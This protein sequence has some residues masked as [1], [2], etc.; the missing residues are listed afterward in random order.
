MN[1]LEKIRYSSKV[2][3]KKRSPEER[4]TM[5]CMPLMLSLSISLKKYYYMTGGRVVIIAIQV[6]RYESGK[7]FVFANRVH[8]DQF[9][10]SETT[11]YNLH[12][13]VLKTILSHSLESH[14]L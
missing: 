7:K 13:L 9:S 2:S 6:N 3:K 8:E 1:F 5:Y 10:A 4:E 11:K 12:H 14:V